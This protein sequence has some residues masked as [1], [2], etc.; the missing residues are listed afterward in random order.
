MLT[1]PGASYLAA[2]TSLARLNYGL[3]GDVLVVM[4]INVVMLALIEVPLICFVVAPDWTPTAIERA[5]GR[6]SCTAAGSCSPA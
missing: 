3:A 6:C 5:K 2:L 4:L 1:L